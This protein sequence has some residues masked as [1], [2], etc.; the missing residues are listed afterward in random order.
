MESRILVNEGTVHAVAT[1]LEERRKFIIRAGGR[2]PRFFRFILGPFDERGKRIRD[3]AELRKWPW[4]DSILIRHGVKDTLVG[5]HPNGFYFGLGIVEG[6]YRPGPHRSSREG[7]AYLRFEA[8]HDSRP[9]IRAVARIDPLAQ[10]KIDK[11]QSWPFAVCPGCK[12]NAF[13]Y[14]HNLE[15]D[16]CGKFEFVG[17]P[18]GEGKWEK[19]DGPRAGDSNGL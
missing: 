12:K 10:L 18:F 15:C 8:E 5:L 1:A 13:V 14:N 9:I 4:A 17:R 16:A 19:I 6:E 7:F 3:L 2:T 11:E